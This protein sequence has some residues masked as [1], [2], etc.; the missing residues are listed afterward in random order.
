VPGEIVGVGGLVFTDG[1]AETDDEAILAYCE[2]A[3]YGIGGKKPTAPEPVEQPD[4]REIHANGP[5]MV[6]TPLRDASVDPRPEDYLAP[7]NAGKADPH[8]P[9]VVAPEIHGSRS[10][11][12]VPGAV[13]EA[14]DDRGSEAGTRGRRTVHDV[15]RGPGRRQRLARSACRTRRPVSSLTRVSRALRWCGD[16]GEEDGGEEDRGTEAVMDVDLGG[17]AQ[18]P[19]KAFDADRLDITP[20]EVAVYVRTPDNITSGPLT[21]TQADI[22]RGAYLYTATQTGLSRYRVVETATDVQITEGAF[23]V[24]PS[25]TDLSTLWAPTLY[26]VASLVPT[27]TV[28]D[29][30]EQQDTFNASTIP[31]DEQVGGY[32]TAITAEIVGT[33]GDVPSSLFGQAKHTAKLGVAWLIER[34]YPPTGQVENVANDFVNDY[35]ASLRGLQEASRGSLTGARAMSVTLDAYTWPEA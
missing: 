32:I 8:G 35:R 14:K 23:Y 30:G 15:V 25:Y 31:T 20:A 19:L 24:W 10:G 22:N 11:L 18:I 5:E 12:A 27:R 29:S 4:S 28:D 3:G 17:S 26:D 6:G 9:L 7:V 1:V 33:I 2:H 34:A 21:V 13:T 16:P